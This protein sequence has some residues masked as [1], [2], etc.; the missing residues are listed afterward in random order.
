MGVKDLLLNAL[1]E[2]LFGVVWLAGA[3][4]A[5]F[6]LP[7]RNFPRG[8]GNIGWVRCSTAQ[9]KRGGDPAVP[10]RRVGS[11]PAALLLPF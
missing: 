11:R 10:G 6:S 5:S 2:Q 8:A 4:S 9:N 1:M 7:E 3:E